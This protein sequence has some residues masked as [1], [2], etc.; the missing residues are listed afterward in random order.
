MKALLLLPLL[1]TF[2]SPSQDAGGTDEGSLVVVLGFKYFKSHQANQKQD[3]PNTA[4]APAMI[5]ENKVY[6]RN[7]RAQAPPGFIDPNTETMD[8]R[9][10]ALDRSV[11]ESRTPKSTPVEGYTY[12]VKIRNAHTQNIE[13]VFWEYQ[14]KESSNPTNVVRRQFLCRVKI[15]P[16]K[17]K[18]LEAFSVL[19][20]SDVVSADSLTNKYGNLF[21]EKIMINLVKYADGSILQRKEWNF[22][23]VRSN[24]ERAMRT[25][26][27]SEM[28]RSL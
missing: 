26:W 13:V 12:Q 20:P 7:A 19:G 27:G 14:F 28:C 21:E 10:A 9:S 8:G 23:E 5:P 4:P 1:L 6:Q 17:E 24:I 18:E 3:L 16:D 15:K 25:P 2:V 11:Q 22:A